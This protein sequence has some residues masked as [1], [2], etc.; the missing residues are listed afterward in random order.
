MGAP[1]ASQLPPKGLCDDCA[2]CRVIH[3]DRGSI[4]FLC[5][6]SFNDTAYP[7]YPRLPVLRCPG[8]QGR[9]QEGRDQ[10]SHQGSDQP[11]DREPLP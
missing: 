4:F 2:F 11:S 10:G 7:K 1:P 3:S 6:R 8:H 5:E 9:V